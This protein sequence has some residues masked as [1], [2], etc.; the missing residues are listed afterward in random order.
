M[1]R[2][3]RKRVLSLALVLTMLF[4]C[5]GGLSFTASATVTLYDNAEDIGHPT[6]KNTEGLAELLSVENN[7][8]SL[9]D[10]DIMMK[11]YE[12][13][14][15]DGGDSFY[16]DRV[17]SRAG[18]ASGNASNGG[19]ADGNTFLTRGRALYMNTSTPS[20]VG[21]G[22]NPAYH[23][24]LGGGN[25]VT[26]SFSQNGAAVQTTEQTATRVN[27]PSN[28]YSTYTLRNVSNV[29][30]QVTKFIAEQ[31][32]AVT[33]MTLVNSGEEDV[34]LKLTAS[35]PY[36]AEPGRVVIS[37]VEQD[38]LTG[39]RMSPSNLTRLNSRLLGDG[40]TLAEN[41]TSLERSV[42]VPAGGSVDAKV[43]FAMTT[44]EI[45][46]SAADY[47][48]FAEM[49]NLTAIRTQKAEYNLYWAQNIPYINVPNPAVEKAI[50]Y[51]WWSERFNSLDANIP[52]YDYQYPITI[53]GV[54]GYNNAIILTQPMHMQDTKWLRS[55]YLI[56]GALLSAGNSSQSSAFL[57][58]PGNRS[59]W[60]N[61]YG[62]Y[63]AQSGTEA[64][65][66]VGG[67]AEMAENLA[68]YF[69]HD[70]TGQLDHYGNHISGQKLITYQNNYMTGNDAD[71]ISM[72]VAR[73]WK[74][75]GE[76]A[77][78]WA[79][80]D[81]AAELY[82]L[83]G[84]TEKAAEYR[85]LADQIQ[86]SVLEVL[87]CDQ[88][89]KFETYGTTRGD[90]HNAEKTHLVK[91]TESNNYNYYAVGL[92]PTD[93]E[94]VAKYGAALRTFKNGK[95][96]PIFPMF[97][98]NQVDN[99]TQPGSNN[100]SNINFTVQ[101]RAYEAA[102][103]TYD[104]AHQYVTGN[105]L[106]LM[107][108]WMAW[109]IY[110]NSGDIRYP[111][112][113]EYYNIDGS[114]RSLDAFYRSW[115]YHNILGNYNYIFFE[116]MA[117]IKPRADD[118]IELFPI[119]MEW[120]HF[121][122][123]NARY[124]GHDLTVSYDKLGD[125]T[126]WYSEMPEGYSLYI[127][128][129]L[130]LTMDRLSHV[131]FD[132]ATGEVDVKDDSQVLFSKGGS[133]IPTALDTV[134]TD[135]RTIELMSK[136]GMY[137]DGE[138]GY[139]ENVAEGAQVTATYTPARARAA[140]WAEKHRA[141][142]SDST[143][144]AVNEEKPDPQAVVDGTTVDMPFWGND[145][146]PND[147]DSLTLQLAEPRTVDMAAI[148]FYND[149]QSGGYT[150][151][152]KYQIE[153]LDGGEWKSVTKQD[154]VPG[155][156]QA[157]QNVIF[158]EAVEADAFRFTFTNKEGHYT[159]VTEIQLFSEGGEREG[160]ASNEPPVVTLTED[161]SLAG[162]LRTG[163]KATV[164]D[165]GKPYD[166]DTSY[167]WEIVAMP[168]G[169]QVIIGNADST[170][171][172]V[173]G[174]K[175]GDYT[176]RFTVSDGELETSAEITV[177]LIQ[178]QTGSLGDDVAPDSSDTGHIY[179][180]YTASWENLYGIANRAFEPSS[181]NMGTGKGW[182]NWSQST[183]SEHY[184]GY[185]WDDPVTVGGF[186][187]YWYDD[188]GGT[189]VPSSFRLQYMD[190]NGAWQD[191]VLI[192]N[193]ADARATN[194]YN[195]VEFYPVTCVDL[196]LIMTTASNA[197][198]IYRWKVY[199][200]IN[201]ER[202]EELEIAT[203]PGVVPNI[204]GS[205]NGIQEDGGVV[206]VPVVWDTVTPEMVAQDGQV[207]VN[208][209]NSSTGLM[210]K[211]TIYVR[212]DLE[213]AIITSVDPVTVYTN[214]GVVPALPRTVRV[215]YNDGAYDNVN[216]TVTWPAITGA[217]L[218]NP[219]RHFYLGEVPGTTTKALLTIVVRGGVSPDQEAA[220]DVIALI[221]YIPDPVT[222][223]SGPALEAAREAYESLT[224]EQ[225]AYV[226][227]YA[228]LV[229]AELEYA[230]LVAE[231]AEAQALAD[232]KY[233]AK[234][235]AQ[236]YA[237]RIAALG[238][239]EET[240][241]ALQELLEQGLADI[242]A[243]ESIEEV[244]A[245]LAA[246]LDAMDE[247]RPAE[248]PFR[249]EDVKDESLE[250]FDAV[251]WAYNHEPQITAGTDATHFSPNVELDRKTA[252]TFLYAAAGKPAFDVNSAE[253]TFTDVKAGKWYTKAILW[254]ANQNPPITSGNG[255]GTFGINTSCKRAHMLTFLYA[256]QGKPAFDE[257]KVPE[258]YVEA[259]KWYTKA[260]KWAYACGIETGEG[261]AFRPNTV[262]TRG[263]TV[264]YLYRTLTGQGL[265]Q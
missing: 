93:P 33:A 174:T 234:Q 49:D 118:K 104:T 71:T 237:D 51:R 123:N 255:D 218:A 17:L 259:G 240:A 130:V 6:F 23:Q 156:P 175:P 152:D 114:G 142:G 172:S 211:C 101:A 106:G 100:F 194:K 167:H 50:L 221:V 122:V 203:T 153:Y 9:S 166:K 14:L 29:T 36:A 83:L 82:T 7:G 161:T 183:G 141:D 233:A 164:S 235:A 65:Y 173:N 184:V 131:V 4:T 262:C 195:R 67:G 134:I 228:E 43:V 223:E 187:I 217:E 46:E 25:L 210:T 139:L 253:N 61:H 44:K 45:P 178:R 110:P 188:G 111:N 163:V 129:E 76:N 136:S 88:C 201:V 151:P 145:A 241:A 216:V 165:D 133:A 116:D 72:A 8:A 245:I 260:A 80:A 32:V 197:S 58:N 107:T 11:I 185:K 56:Y 154:R 97:T 30:L 38:E 70:A 190:V 28:W 171:A 10:K 95:E 186:D 160:A 200:S 251:Y 37:G 52:G 193:V 222:L 239:D 86:S 98:A 90:S 109:L 112:N 204:P 128:G 149:R 207:V 87:W 79:A 137:Q 117:G 135:A 96:F 263:T 94:S 102:Y 138:G 177:T 236:A 220:E 1:K 159:A 60:N 146:S 250:Y 39:T 21:F 244:Q 18:V 75:H 206:S 182:G 227:N 3:S 191:V 162:N 16:M 226:S 143:S 254:A 212:S 261:G 127:D 40:F 257:T 248:Q 209:I 144:R 158:F 219:G 26:V 105:M 247:L 205:V 73:G 242:E 179:S 54:L 243:A 108:E 176:L 103:R 120:D 20:V 265:D 225:K 31:N 27:Q 121:L 15:A 89:Q 48:R 68:Y 157:N 24:P 78:V 150:E 19:N 214:P 22:G 42:T 84:D 126:R 232:A 189:R 199:N 125:E 41:G 256:Q 91:V 69:G 215:G 132:P 170:L 238:L 77:Y 229:L 181:S 198:G 119:D 34:E 258:G 168:E 246:L 115:I 231:D 208:G 202:L 99:Q 196:R 2:N 5:V 264:L 252:M 47:V 74:A 13:D 147:K 249:F 53:E 113:S 64:F 124:H 213:N 66:V 81:R 62:Q 63:I 92:V 57:D 35:S 180:D 192:T 85:S 12:K 140:S 230:M 224:E 148:Y 59:N 169:A 155:A 55:P